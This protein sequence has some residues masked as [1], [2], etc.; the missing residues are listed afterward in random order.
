M[1]GKI[2]RAKGQTRKIANKHEHRGTVEAT[3]STWSDKRV[4]VG[5]GDAG[6]RGGIAGVEA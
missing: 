4:G 3:V 5:D 6:I 2:S 1:G